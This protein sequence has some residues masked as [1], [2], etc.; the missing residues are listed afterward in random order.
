MGEKKVVN[1]NIALSLGLLCII[2]AASV[3]GIVIYSSNTDYETS[4]THT[5]LEYANLSAQLEAANE[6]ISSL[7]NQLSI[8]QSELLGNGTHSNDL[9]TQV[10]VL[11]SQLIAINGS[12]KTIQ[13]YYNSLMYVLNTDNHDLS[14]DLTT[15]N[16][17]IANLQNQISEFNAIGNLTVSKVWVNNQ[18]VTQQAGS[19]S[20][21]SESADY[22]GYVSIQVSSSTAPNTYANVTY[23]SHGVNYNTQINV[24]TKGT[25]N[26]PIL[27]TSNIIVAVGNGLSSGIAAE[28]VTITYYY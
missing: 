21:W 14:V 18:T 24:G 3:V 4:H 27:P 26:F 8:L 5:D 1:R 23:S 7:N 13:D 28:T 12:V 19:Y 6:N 2:L 20:S 22:A 11:T 15:A 25:A 9:Q 16:T 10:D 17:Q